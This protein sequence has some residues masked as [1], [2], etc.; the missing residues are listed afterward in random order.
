MILFNKMGIY[1]SAQNF[2]RYSILYIYCIF[3]LCVCMCARTHVRARGSVSIF[4]V[5]AAFASISDF[6]IIQQKCT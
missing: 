1:F 2:G 4:F 5:H 6:E 3:Y